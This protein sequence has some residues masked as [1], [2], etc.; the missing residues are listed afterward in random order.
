M[1]AEKRAALHTEASKKT[2]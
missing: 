1:L 2:R